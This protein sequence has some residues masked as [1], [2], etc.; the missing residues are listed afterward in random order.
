M[1]SITIML[2]LILAGQITFSQDW[3]VIKNRSEEDYELKIDYQFR[4]RAAPEKDEVNY[5]QVIPY[6]SDKSLLP[7]LSVWVTIK[8]IKEEEFRMKLIESGGK[9]VRSVKISD[10]P[11]EIEFGFKEDFMEDIA[12]RKYILLVQDK[13]KN[14]LNK[15]VIEVDKEGNFIVNGIINGKI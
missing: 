11:L 10:K 7:F 4:Q 9:M 15:I 6:A 8:N 2:V 14:D 1:K 12:P 13:K 5:L 3:Q